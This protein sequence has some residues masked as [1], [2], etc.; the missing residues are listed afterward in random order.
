MKTIAT[1]TSKGQVT[2]P[3]SVRKELGIQA[4]DNLEFDCHAGKADVRP[5]RARLSSAGVL[6]KYL[7][8]GWRA[9]SVGEMDADIGRH[10]AEKYRKHDR[11]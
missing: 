1:V 9:K 2:I 7:P 6:N 8:K 3:L 5:V 10:L 11:R 4:G